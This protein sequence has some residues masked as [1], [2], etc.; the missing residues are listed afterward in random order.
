MG[1]ERKE[2]SAYLRGLRGRPGGELSIGRSKPEPP[3]RTRRAAQLCWK[4]T[5]GLERGSYN[6]PQQA[7]GTTLRVPHPIYLGGGE[8]PEDYPEYGYLTG[9]RQWLGYVQ[10]VLMK[11]KALKFL[12][13]VT[14]YLV[15]LTGGLA[16]GYGMVANLPQLTW[17]GVVVGGGGA[18]IAWGEDA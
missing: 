3:Q 12:H 10:E 4:P 17:I 13:W 6:P 5:Q 2:R 9:Y 14:P 11:T 7:S 18:V 8:K 16:A 1:D 15:V